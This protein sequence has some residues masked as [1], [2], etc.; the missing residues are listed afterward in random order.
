MQE[1]VCAMQVGESFVHPVI[2]EKLVIYV[3]NVG[4]RLGRKYRTRACEFGRKVERL[5]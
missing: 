5:K 2:D 3:S 4:R 1:R